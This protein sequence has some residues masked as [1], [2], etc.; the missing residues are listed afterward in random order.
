MWDKSISDTRPLS[1]THGCTRHINPRYV[2]STQIT[3]LKEGL[4]EKLLIKIRYEN[5]DTT[6]NLPL[7]TSSRRCHWISVP[8]RPGLSQSANGPVGLNKKFLAWQKRQLILAVTLI[9]QNFY[10]T[11]RDNLGLRPMSFLVCIV[12]AIKWIL[13]TMFELTNTKQK[14]STQV[15]MVRNWLYIFHK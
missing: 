9:G 6:H 14:W 4:F 15:N 11:Q 2:V 7:P 8:L 12:V 5:I 3:L 10:L 1:R 13:F